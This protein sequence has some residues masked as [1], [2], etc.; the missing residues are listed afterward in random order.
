MTNQT[1]LAG[2]L[3]D[4]VETLAPGAADFAADVERSASANLSA[5]LQC[6]KCSSGCPV[7]AQVDVVP[8]ALLRL[9]Q[10][11][12]RDA[13]LGSRMIWLCTS[14]QTCMTRCPQKVDIAAMNDALRRMSLAAGQVVKGSRVPAFNS[15]FLM[16][17]RRLGRM[18]EMGLMSIFKMRTM[19]L[20]SDVN[21]MPMMLKK[22]KLA[23]FPPM[24]GG[25]KARRVLFD[26]VRRAGSAK[27]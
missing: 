19:D 25:G 17:I 21:K 13:V 26:R 18:Y 8:H 12:Q 16:I 24:I 10:L 20:V 1:Q 2:R 4:R 6:G 14:C 15:T 9:V 11:G 7:A 27:P 23:M 3:G 22:G 5:C